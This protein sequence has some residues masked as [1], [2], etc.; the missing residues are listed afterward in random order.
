MVAKKDATA[1]GNALA[2][3]KGLSRDQIKAEDNV[4]KCEEALEGAKRDLAAISENVLPDLMDELEME[5]FV[6]TSGDEVTVKANL[7]GSIT[8]GNADKAFK[9]LEDKGHEKLI[10]RT[11]VIVFSKEEETWANQFEAQMRRRKKPLHVTRKKEVHAGTLKSFI[12]EQLEKGVRFPL[13]T[14]GV[15]ERRRTVIKRKEKE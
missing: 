8:Q 6:T 13:K 1:G 7:F 5:K 3:L 2:R 14:F 12:A 4:K 15:H 9:W 11:F 10:K